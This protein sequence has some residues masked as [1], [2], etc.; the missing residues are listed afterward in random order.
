MPELPEVETVC[1]GL[2]AVLE[3]RVLRHL[4]LRRKDLRFPFPAGLAA[5][6]EG[7]RVAA[8]RR[9]AKYI[10]IH[11]EDGGVL[12]AH[13][14]MSGR[15]LIGPAEGLVLETH[16]HVVFHTD[17]GVAVRF[18]DARRFGFLDHARAEDLGRHKLLEGLGPEPLGNEFSGPVLAEKLAG[19]LAPIKAALLDQKIVAG[20]GNIYVSEALF[21]ARLSPLRSAGTVSGARAEK[22]VRAIK[23]VLTRAIAAGGSSLRDYVQTSGELGYFQ[24]Q[25][26][27]YGKEGEPCPGCTCAHGILR[28]VQSNRA[29]F[30]CAKR[31]R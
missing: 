9:R 3:T 16:D 21:V 19:K 5:L 23:D 31:Q 20:L 22:L 12:I 1:R 24:H 30:Y 11:L 13:L 18:N 15:M 29:T 4:E 8:V 28:I 10:L 25:W 26:A 14:G 7:R 2:A 17:H 6:V 27:V